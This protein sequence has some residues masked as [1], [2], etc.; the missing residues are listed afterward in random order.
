M[1]LPLLLGHKTVKLGI[2][3]LLLLLDVA[4]PRPKGI[5]VHFVI[6]IASRLLRS[7]FKFPYPL[8]A[9]Q[10]TFRFRL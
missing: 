2:I 6:H 10:K 3:I 1:L 8:I 9:P 4:L 7:I 5:S